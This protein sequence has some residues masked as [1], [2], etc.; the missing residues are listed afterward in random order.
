MSSNAP[1]R[2]RPIGRG[3]KVRKAILAATLSELGR[4]GYAAL[5][6]ENV[7]SAAGVHK[8]TVYRRWDDRNSLIVD[9]LGDQIAQDIP[10][11][12]TGSFEADLRALARAFVGWATS[13]SGQAILAAMLSDAVRVP[14]IAEARQ[15][16]FEGR[17]RMAAGVIGR[18]I[19][20][21]EVPADTDPEE[22]IKCLVAP[23][24]LRLL[25][26]GEELDA[27]AA[28]RA[29]TVTVTAVR[30]GILGR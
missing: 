30:A 15:R 13:D 25:I 3:E 11:P 22:V 21:E 26:T 1:G 6:V 12:D 28:D 4:T 16:I 2:Q 24:Y 18:A 23:L 27:T 20:R 29:V 5:T 10:I 14:E 17:V 19:E 8:T 9:A 7:A